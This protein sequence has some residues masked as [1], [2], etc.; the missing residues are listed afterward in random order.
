M[1][2][3][4]KKL[5]EIKK[6]TQSMSNKVSKLTIT[7]E[8]NVLNATE[9][10]TQIKARAK[11]IEEIRLGYTKPL[12]DS[13]RK[14]NADFKGAL[15]PLSEM[16]GNIKRA[17]IDY[18][19]EIERKRQAEEDRLRKEAEAKAKAEAKK[20]KISVKKVLE[21]TPMPIVEKQ[22]KTIASKSGSVKARMVTKFRIVDENKVPKKYWVI[23]EKLI[24]DDVRNG[25]MIIAGVEIYQEEELSVY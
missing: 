14:I 7:N 8:K 2:T 19:A 5:A 17:I 4:D 25:Q 16:E 1:D 10:L 23:D 18:R 9:L 11:R 20:K 12:N 15:K 21:N 6:D 3:Q 22:D 24:R 13:L